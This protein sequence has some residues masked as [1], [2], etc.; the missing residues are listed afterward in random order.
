MGI[1]NRTQ[2]RDAI[3][4]LANSVLA[5]VKAGLSEP[6]A[7]LW[8]DIE[9]DGI[10][11]RGPWVRV[12]VNHN[13]GG[14]GAFGD[15]QARWQKNGVLAIQVFTPTGDGLNLSDQICD[16]LERGFE[17]STAGD[18]A[19]W[20]TNAIAQEVGADGGWYQSNFSVDFEYDIVH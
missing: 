3:L 15:N 18:G 17:G 8:A 19:V 2:A 10:P 16:G 4:G 12:S 9:E 5:G 7:V 1:A 13:Q 20:F 11:K 14:Q 6:L